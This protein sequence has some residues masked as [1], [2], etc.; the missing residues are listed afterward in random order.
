MMVYFQKSKTCSRIRVVF[1]RKQL[2]T[3]Q[4]QSTHHRIDLHL[5][6]LTCDVSALYK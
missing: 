2:R 3:N 6:K 1:I 5:I 4:N